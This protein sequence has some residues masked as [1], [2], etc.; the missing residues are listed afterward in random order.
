MKQ[1][2][3]VI[4]NNRK[5]TRLRLL[6]FHHA[7]GSALSFSPFIHH[8]PSDVELAFFELPGRGIQADRAFLPDFISARDY[9]LEGVRELTDRP[10]IIIGH[11]L[12]A[13]LAHAVAVSLPAEQIGFVRKVIISGSR[14]PACVA[15]LATHPKQPFIIRTRQSIAADLLRIGRDIRVLLT[16][17]ELLEQAITATGHDFHLLDTYCRPNTPPQDLSLELWL[18]RTDP[19]VP[20]EEADLWS[21]ETLRP[22][23]IRIFDSSHFFLFDHPAPKKR[24]RE[25]VEENLA[26]MD[27]G[28]PQRHEGGKA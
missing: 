2:S 25:I 14:S 5:G 15:A 19:A 20:L 17:P 1:Q 16:D 7:G 10:V 23:E 24:L 9:L 4:Y 18:G 22:L 11:S 28:I 8:L 27:E 12:G 13:L 21:T 3:Y 26:S 6:C